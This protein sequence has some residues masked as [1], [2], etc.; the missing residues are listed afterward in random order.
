MTG[1]E[2]YEQVNWIYVGWEL[3]NN[4]ALFYSY[5][6]IFTERLGVTILMSRLRVRARSEPPAK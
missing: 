6:I 4:L 5:Y 2:R 3:P 1:Y